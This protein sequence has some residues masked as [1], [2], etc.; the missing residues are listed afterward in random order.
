MLLPS[1]RGAFQEEKCC[2]APKRKPPGPCQA[3]LPELASLSPGP[4]CC[5]PRESFVCTGQALTAQ[6]HQRGSLCKQGGR[7][8]IAP[9]QQV[10]GGTLFLQGGLAAGQ[11][12]SPC[13]W[14]RA[15]AK[16]SIP[17]HAPRVRHSEALM[18][19]VAAA[20]P[21]R[22]FA[23]SGTAALPEKG[24]GETRARR[25]ATAEASNKHRVGV[26]NR[27]AAATLP[28]PF[29]G[30]WWGGSPPTTAFTTLPG[31]P[32]ATGTAP[33]AAQAEQRS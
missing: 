29:F 10:Q 1:F 23:W 12:F 4:A 25:K 17:T 16:Q 18:A 24:H 5:T 8:G 21:R 26:C 22:P 20:A 32:S 33:A 3:G 7:R 28:S 31:S 2:S 14:S 6:V 13:S 15:R 30:D 19:P 27:L 11:Q 9:S